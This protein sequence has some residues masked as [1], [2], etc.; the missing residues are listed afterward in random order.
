MSAIW[1]EIGK[2]SNK[3]F[4]GIKELAM[5]TNNPSVETAN[6]EKLLYS[7]DQRI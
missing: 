3:P 2:I 4:V 6:V 7:H 5:D 1:K